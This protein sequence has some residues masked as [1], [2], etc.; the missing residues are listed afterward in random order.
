M[1]NTSASRAYAGDNSTESRIDLP[2][3]LQVARIRALV[4]WSALAIMTA[5]FAYEFLQFSTPQEDAAI[6]MRYAQHIAHGDGIVWNIGGPPVDGG[7][8]FL[9]MMA[10]AALVASGMTPPLAAYALGIG[11]H[12]LTAIIIYL[13]VSRLAGQPSFIAGLCA[14][15]FLCGPGLRLISAGFT[16]PVFAMTAAIC[17][18]LSLELIS[19][20][21]DSALPTWSLAFALLAMGLTRPEGVFLAAFMMLAIVTTKPMRESVRPMMA[22]I[23]VFLVVGGAYFVWRWRYF[24]YPLPNPY[25]RKGGFALHPHALLVSIR[26]AA[27]LLFVCA[28]IVVLGL[29]NSDSRRMA[30][31]ASIPI[32]LFIAIWV[33]VS[34]EMDYMMRFQYPILP[35]A[36]MSVPFCLKGSIFEI[37]RASFRSGSTRR[38]AVYLACIW[39][40]AGFAGLFCIDSHGVV[41][42]YAKAQVGKALR[43]YGA[44]YVLA[45]TEAGLLP[46]YSEWTT[47][48][49]WGLNDPW[50]AHHHGQITEDYLGRWHPDV[51]AMHGLPAPPGE[52]L[53]SDGRRLSGRP[54][55]QT[56]LTVLKRYAESHH[57]RAAARDGDSPSD[58]MIYYVR[59]DAPDASRIVASIRSA[60]AEA[61]RH[62]P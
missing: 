37:S 25:Y 52:S 36:L 22:T 28:P 24:G 14:A 4:A 2:E 60:I 11:C 9:S 8:D 41:H 20:Q 6:L 17:W 50:I 51:I 39:M 5:F 47:I 58:A 43:P 53:E 56:M 3:T 59:N 33:L 21:T 26:N 32:V 42:D 34:D 12:L 7:T 46:L 61:A 44:P 19:K 10:M 57:Y 27:V 23:C 35:L 62:R 38:I 49:T 1:R 18:Y 16:T 54:D 15:Y 13:A 30:I 40:I 29:K 55:W 45:T 31:A 48:D